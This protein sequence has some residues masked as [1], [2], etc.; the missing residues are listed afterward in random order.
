MLLCGTMGN[1][2]QYRK[3]VLFVCWSNICRSPAAESVLSQYLKKRKLDDVFLVE[4]AGVC[5]DEKPP[6][7]SY[8]VRRTAR[9]RGYRLKNDPR[10][11]RRTDLC[12]YDLVIATDQENLKALRTFN[13]EPLS[14]IRLL[15]DYLPPTWPRDIPDP[16]NADGEICSLV[17]DMLE[18]ACPL[19]TEELLG[20]AVPIREQVS[21]K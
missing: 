18:A 5:I 10:L 13:S 12:K 6:K 19:I 17:F 14:T 7:P 20:P 2:N 16:M 1:S 9:R 8:W 11:L 4:S 3:S 21:C 15:S